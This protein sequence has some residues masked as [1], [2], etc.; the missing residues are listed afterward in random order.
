VSI[1]AGRRRSG[2]C[3]CIIR[4]IRANRAPR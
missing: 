4:S 2:Q 3:C 1:V